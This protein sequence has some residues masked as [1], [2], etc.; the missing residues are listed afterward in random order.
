M[1]WTGSRDSVE[2]SILERTPFAFYPLAAGA[3]RGAGPLKV[4]GNLV[5]TARGTLEALKLIRS[6]KPDAILATGGYVSVPTVLAGWLLRC[7]TL[8][9]LPDME[10][11]LA[12]RLLS[13]FAKRVAVSFDRVATHFAPRKVV[14]SGYPVRQ[15]LHQ[16]DRRQ[17]R[18]ALGLEDALPAILILGGSRGARSIN[19]AVAQHL[20]ELLRIAQVIHISGPVDLE[21]LRAARAHLAPDLRKRYHLHAYLHEQMIDA[22]VAADLVVAR[23][24]ASVLG[25]FPAVGV[26]AILVPYP[27]AGPNQ[28]VN[29]EYLRDRGAAVIVPDHELREQLMI[30]VDELVA[31]PERLDAMAA[32][33]R[34][35]AMPTAARTLASELVALA[36]DSRNG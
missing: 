23:A 3:V 20:D 29:A 31:S 28:H 4:L 10:P 12:V 22:L 25:E 24:G 15:A 1:C 26:P 2:E 30:V 18:V 36:K 7:P 17:S 8:V 19:Q 21:T 11:G 14:V 34:R 33:A 6:V 13:V 5:Q 9:Y 32:A 16:G 27:Y 35:L